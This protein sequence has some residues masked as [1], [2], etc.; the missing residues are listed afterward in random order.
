[1]SS[2]TQ[3]WE[4]ARQPYQREH[5]TP[6]FYEHPEIFRIASLLGE[7]DSTLYRWTLDTEDDLKLLRAVYDR[8]QNRDTFGY[9]E[10]LALMQ[11]EPDLMDLNSRVLQK[12]SLVM[13]T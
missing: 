4:E 7:I 6:Y 2:L 1:M 5:V 3:A 13:G 11:R 10:V 12:S 9:A 8:F